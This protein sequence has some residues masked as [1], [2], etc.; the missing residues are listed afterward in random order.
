MVLVATSIALLVAALMVAF[1]VHGALSG[2]YSAAL[3]RFATNSP[4]GD[5]FDP[6]ALQL[7]FR[8]K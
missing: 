5:A 6:D 7:A 3:Y 2:I 8:S 1:L 4:V